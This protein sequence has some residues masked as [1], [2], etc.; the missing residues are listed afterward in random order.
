[1]YTIRWELKKYAAEINLNLYRDYN[2]YDWLHLVKF[3][4]VFHS[5]GFT[6]KLIVYKN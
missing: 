2:Q 3:C 6:T 5:N 1:M 4:Y